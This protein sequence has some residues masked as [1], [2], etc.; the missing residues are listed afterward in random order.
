MKSV[1]FGG[2]R[3]SAIV[4]EKLLENN[5]WP[6]LIIASPDEPLGKKRIPTPPPL[7]SA[8]VDRHLVV[9]Q[10]ESLKDEVILKKIKELNPDL[11]I[12]AA[13]GKLIPKTMLDLFPSGILNIHPSLLPKYRGPSP[14]Q[15]AILN[16]DK[17]TGVSIILLD[18]QMDHG[19]I[20]TQEKISLTGEEYFQELYEKL[21]D[22]GGRLLAKTILL[23][24]EN[25]I[26]PLA[27]DE[28]KTSR[29]KKLDWQDGK[30]DLNDSVKKTFAKIRALSHEP[31]CWVELRIKNNE[32]RIL[33]ITKAH[34]GDSEFTLHN[35]HLG[36]QDINGELALILKN[37]YL[38]L[39]NVQ[40]EG[41][42]IMTGKEFL[43]G[44]RKLI[45]NN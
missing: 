10:P 19:P 16:N 6:D 22:L 40:P 45:L 39:D 11:G 29:C 38:I 13:Y 9:S 12:V 34:L 31:G 30:I 36:L 20:L 24:L 42:R 44:Y 28:T 23:W 21:A 14:I 1:F 41:K 26:I 5:V 35:S 32:L 37:G 43:N 7:K 25:K 2:N 4:L 3:L 8:A 18:E 27:Q 33:K 15:T 17:E